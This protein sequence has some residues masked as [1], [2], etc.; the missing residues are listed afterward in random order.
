MPY[1]LRKLFDWLEKK[2]RSHDSQIP[3]ETRE[4][5][6][7]CIPILRQSVIYVHRVHLAF[8]YL[9]GIFYHIAKRVAGIQY[10]SIRMMELLISL[11]NSQNVSR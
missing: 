10:V 5:L 7:R 6:L 9:R 11:L 3:L 8:F 2:L 1:C 4:F